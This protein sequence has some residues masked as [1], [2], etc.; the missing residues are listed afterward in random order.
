MVAPRVG[1]NRVFVERDRVPNELLELERVD[2][3]QSHGVGRWEEAK[4]T[5]PSCSASSKEVVRKEGYDKDRGP[6]SEQKLRYAD[7]EAK[8]D[9]GCGMNSGTKAS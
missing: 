3:D 5:S 8:L 7:V 4:P 9:C 2:I 1:Q 6:V